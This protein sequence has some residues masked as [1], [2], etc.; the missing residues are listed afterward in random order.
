MKPDLEGLAQ[1]NATSVVEHVLFTL[2][3][4]GGPRLVSEPS[5]V[6]CST[7]VLR[8]T[9][10]FFMQGPTLQVQASSQQLPDSKVFLWLFPYYTV[11]PGRQGSFPRHLYVSKAQ[12]MI[13][14]TAGPQ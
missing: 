12:E 14:N 6:S 2:P 7:D 13:W 11:S 8:Q 9:W 4:G 10:G 3:P 1:F 5:S